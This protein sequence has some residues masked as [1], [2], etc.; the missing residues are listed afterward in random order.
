M[1]LDYYNSY[2]KIILVA[3]PVKNANPDCMV[4]IFI[5]GTH[6]KKLHEGSDGCQ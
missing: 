5:S 6:D 3:N 1:S 4:R 2:Q